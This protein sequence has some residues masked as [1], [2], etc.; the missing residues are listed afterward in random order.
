MF[1]KHALQL[2][3]AWDIAK[4]HQRGVRF[5]VTIARPMGHSF[6]G[7]LF[8]FIFLFCPIF[9]S[10]VTRVETP[11]TPRPA[12]GLNL[13]LVILRTTRLLQ[14]ASRHLWPW[15]RGARGAVYAPILLSPCWV[16]PLPSEWRANYASPCEPA[17]L[18]P[19]QDQEWN[20]ELKT[21][22]VQLHHSSV[23]DFYSNRAIKN[24]VCELVVNIIVPGLGIAPVALQYSTVIFFLTTFLSMI[25][26]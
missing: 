1:R 6:R 26:D 11:H 16:L 12:G 25:T 22:T 19:W 4:L 10:P 24:M 17:K 7:K 15:F 21:A 23:T 2:R 3:L 8:S 18:S 9:F 5:L 20:G 13:D 14:A